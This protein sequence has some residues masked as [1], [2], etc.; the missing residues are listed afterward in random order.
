M[1]KQS[2]VV[3]VTSIV[4]VTAILCALI[5]AYYDSEIAYIKAGY[6]RTT[7]PGSASSEWVKP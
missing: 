1:S 4:C 6:T 5:F 3:L 2:A 7:L